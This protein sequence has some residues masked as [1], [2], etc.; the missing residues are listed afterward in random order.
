MK[1]TDE[2]IARN[3]AIHLGRFD[4]NEPSMRI[5]RDDLGDVHV[6]DTVRYVGHGGPFGRDLSH[7]GRTGIVT[8]LRN[9][10]GVGVQFPHHP[11]G[12]NLFAHVN[13]FRLVACIHVP[14]PDN[15]EILCLH[16]DEVIFETSGGLWEAPANGGAAR[17][18]EDNPSEQH[19][20]DESGE[21]V[22]P[23]H[24]E[25][26]PVCGTRNW[27]HVQGSKGLCEKGH[28]FDRAI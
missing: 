12:T 9:E 19:E 26:C 18:C 8:E 17:L 5:I 2:E 10:A 7:Y 27:G 28:L 16:C 24:N 13:V 11:K 6:G 3:R 23:P 25:P 4:L 20:P 22:E 15:D 21:T 14:E 1:Y